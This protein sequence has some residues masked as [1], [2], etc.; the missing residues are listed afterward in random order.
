MSAFSI[1][2]S[3]VLVLWSIMLVPHFIRAKQWRLFGGTAMF[4]LLI[5]Y[6]LIQDHREPPWDA[7]G[8]IFMISFSS[9]C[10]YIFYLALEYQRKK[11]MSN[12]DADE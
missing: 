12:E 4:L 3:V 7:I 5:E 11:E 9:A 1:F 10:G 6:Q 2:N 8:A